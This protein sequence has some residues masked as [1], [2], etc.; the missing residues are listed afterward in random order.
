VAGVGTLTSVWARTAPSDAG[1]PEAGQPASGDEVL[2]DSGT[3]EVLAQDARL[4]SCD[5][6][7]VFVVVPDGATAPEAGSTYLL[8]TGRGEDARWTLPASAEV[9][10]PAPGGVSA[11]GGGPARILVT[12]GALDGIDVDPE[13]VTAYVTLDPAVPDALDHLRTAA[14]Q[15]DPV[16]YASPIAQERITSI[17]GG[18][19][20]VLQVGTVALLVLIGASM[21]V[22]VIEQLRERRQLLAVLVA[23]GTRRRTLGGSVL[24]Q[25]AIPVVLGLALAVVTGSV[26]ALALQAAVDAPLAFDW[27]GVGVA[28][29]AAALVVLLTTAA[30]LPLLWRLARP[31]GLRSE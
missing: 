19:R 28:S 13:S 21:L 5:D 15:V 25:V 7:D 3:C 22:N 31:T 12:P 6:G 27:R 17:L 2:V 29:G 20:Q 11:M 16:A 23:F 14:A 4:G 24:F 10:E 30:S 9:V 8:G 1:Q 26:L 18:V